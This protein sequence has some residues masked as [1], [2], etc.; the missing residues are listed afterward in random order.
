MCSSRYCRMPAQMKV[1]YDAAG[2]LGCSG[3]LN[4]K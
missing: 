2:S 3:K 1:L 4:G